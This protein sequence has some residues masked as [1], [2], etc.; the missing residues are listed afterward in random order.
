MSRLI[1]HMGLRTWLLIITSL[2]RILMTEHPVWLLS[3]IELVRSA[4]QSFFLSQLP[5]MKCRVQNCSETF[6]DLAS[7]LNLQL[8][9]RMLEKTSPWP[10]EVA[11]LS[12]RSTFSF[13][14]SPVVIQFLCP[15]PAQGSPLSQHH[16]L[17]PLWLHLTPLR[18]FSQ[19]LAGGSFCPSL[20]MVDLP[21]SCPEPF[22][23]HS[24]LCLLTI[25]P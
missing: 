18:S 24:M 2:V 23:S 13:L 7:C 17:L 10:C 14:F 8:T 16:L 19:N 25:S 21:H 1:Y 12:P 22:R 15:S 9:Y 3:V 5:S 4:M 20:C 11:F 6:H